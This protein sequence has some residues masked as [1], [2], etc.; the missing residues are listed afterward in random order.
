MKRIRP[1][2]DLDHALALATDSAPALIA[3]AVAILLAWRL[4]NHLSR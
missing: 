3:I 2:T 4:A 1:E